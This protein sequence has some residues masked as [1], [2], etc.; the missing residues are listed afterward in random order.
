MRITRLSLLLALLFCAGYSHAQII[1]D[2]ASWT[3]EVKK[4]GDKQY[5]L[6][7]HLKLKPHWHIWSFN[8]G[9]DGMLIPPS[10]TF[11]KR[12]GVTFKGKVTEH[13]KMKSKVMI[14]GDPASRYFEGC[15][16][17]SDQLACAGNLAKEC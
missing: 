9:G 4:S 1:K 15:P 11:D 2:P 5:K 13:G 8:P 10:F 7:T 3:Y 16:V 14:D 12:A 17:K 6:I